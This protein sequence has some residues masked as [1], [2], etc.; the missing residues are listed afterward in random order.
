M[1]AELRPGGRSGGLSARRPPAGAS[2]EAVHAWW[3]S[4]TR[5]QQLAIIAASPGSVGNLDGVPA[6]ARDAANRNALTRDL[7]DLENTED[8]GSLTDDERTRQ[9]NAEAAQLGLENVEKSRDPVTGEPIVGQLYIYDPD[10]FDGDGRIAVSAGNL[11][12]ADNVTV[13]VPG[14]GNLVLTG[15]LGDVMKESARIALSL[16][17]ARAG[18]ERRVIVDEKRLK[19]EEMYKEMQEK[20]DER[21]KERQAELGPALARFARK[22]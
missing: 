22:E 19:A 20:K 1:A 6:S 11:D 12:T 18:D 9:E 8:E 21:H 2:P 14:F 5:P 10:A 3:T 16:V 13:Q 7:A 15:Q 17:R 4:L